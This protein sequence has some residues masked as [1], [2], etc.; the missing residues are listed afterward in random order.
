MLTDVALKA[1]KPNSRATHSRAAIACWMAPVTS[2]SGRR[3]ISRRALWASLA[4][5]GV[6]ADC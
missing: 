3:E 1:L 2:A 5:V 4:A 6:P